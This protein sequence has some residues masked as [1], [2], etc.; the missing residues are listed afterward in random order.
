MFARHL[1]RPTCHPLRH[2][3]RPISNTKHYD[4]L[5]IKY[6]AVQAEIK[7]AYFRAAKQ[8]HPDINPS[9]EAAQKFRHIVDAY[10]VLR[11]PASRAAYDAGRPVET[12]NRGREQTRDEQRRRGPRQSY[13]EWK[14][15]I[16][17]DFTNFSWHLI[18][19]ED[20]GQYVRQMETGFVHAVAAAQARDFAP[21]RIWATEYRGW[22]A[23]GAVVCVLVTPVVPVV[24]MFCVHLTR[25]IDEHAEY[26]LAW[27]DA[28]WNSIRCPPPHC[29]IPSCDFFSHC[30]RPLV[31]PY[32][33]V[34]T[35]QFH[36]PINCFRDMA[37]LRPHTA[38]RRRGAAYSSRLCCR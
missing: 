8:Y 19:V 24:M 29:V 2:H 20:V 11:N 3:R 28:R 23:T 6:D 26:L 13:A 12:A 37:R 16:F 31:M 30:C 14:R 33:Y 1:F 34:A 4:T 17:M 22:V 32:G 27:C 38:A 5:G 18:G 15:E 10:K 7:M 21:A 36:S 9:R 25:K 35:L